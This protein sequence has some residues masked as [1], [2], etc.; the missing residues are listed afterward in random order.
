MGQTWDKF[1]VYLFY[2]YSMDIWQSTLGTY[3]ECYC[4][5]ASRELDAFYFD[6]WKKKYMSF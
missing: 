6:A 4:K 2:N 3:K 1:N 5:K